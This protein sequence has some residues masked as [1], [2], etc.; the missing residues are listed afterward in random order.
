MLSDYCNGE[1]K[2]M[3]AAMYFFHVLVR[4]RGEEI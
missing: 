1:R 3:I 2:N 4:G